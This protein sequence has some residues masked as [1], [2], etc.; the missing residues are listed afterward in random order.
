MDDTLKRRFVGTWFKDQM[1]REIHTEFFMNNDLLAKRCA[2]VITVLALSFFSTST[3]VT[4]E[5]LPWTLT[6]VQI[7]ATST[8]GLQKV[9]M[10]GDGRIGFIAS[11]DA[12]GRVYWYERIDQLQWKRHTLVEGFT[13]IEGVDVGD[14]N[15]DGSMEVVI[16]EQRPGRVAIARMQTDDPAGPWRSV[17]IDDK[18]PMAQSGFV[19]DVSGN[20]KPDIIYTYDGRVDGV[21]GVYWLENGGGDPLD[22]NNW[23]KHEMVQI[24]GGHGL[25]DGWV[26]FPDHSDSPAIV[27]STRLAWN[28]AAVGEVFWL[29]RPDDP[30]KPW[31]KHTI[32]TNVSSRHVTVGDF[33]GNGQANDVFT[34]RRDAGKGLYWY[35]INQDGDWTE[36]VV[37][38]QRQHRTISSHDFTGNGVDE[39]IVTEF[40]GEN[41]VCVYARDDDGQFRLMA[42]HPHTKSDDRIVYLD[43]TG[44]GRDEFVTT[45]ENDTF[46]YWRLDFN[47]PGEPEPVVVGYGE[48][49]FRIG[50]LLHRDDFDSLDNWIVQAQGRDSAD[51]VNITNN[52]L[53][54][55]LPG[56]SATIWYRHKLQGPITIVYN[57]RAPRIA[58]GGP[59]YME[60]DF[61]CF[62]HASDPDT[63]DRVITDS[64]RYDGRFNSYHR[65]R[66]YYASTGGGANSTTRFRRYPRRGHGE[67]LFLNDKDGKPRHMI[68]PDRT[69]T[70]QLVA[71]DDLIQYIVDG[72]VVYEIRENDIVTTSSN[73]KVMYTRDRFPPYTEGWFAFRLTSSRHIYSNFRVYRLV[74]ADG[75]GS[76]LNIVPTTTIVKEQ[77]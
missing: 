8:D 66:G 21:G 52:Q 25:H 64:Q 39:V 17:I 70:V 7:D 28:R 24:N 69:Y 2:S 68:E 49:T 63:P 76:L 50:P 12:S 55:D 45:S 67:H 34:I 46:D 59:R 20:G 53:N 22:V 33:N 42:R 71:Y 62:W 44:D 23:T 38:R 14:F 19:T 73:N 6:R 36:H 77:R 35:E 51:S 40:G 16:L 41:A 60:R 57:V 47:P 30:R 54:A 5:A 58:N 10:R 11:G 37:T 31:I 13:E 72:Q 4:A 29:Q 18:A 26:M 27:A 61:N 65:M 9:D 3:S 56:Q 15:G 74:S 48:G 75:S 1:P 43:I 32:V